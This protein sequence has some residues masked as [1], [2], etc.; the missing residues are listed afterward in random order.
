MN[1]IHIILA[2][3]LAA[4]AL[5]GWAYLGQRDKAVTHEVREQQAT[6]AAVECSNGTESLQT[7]AQER[8]EAAAPKIAAAKKQAEQHNREADRILTTPP[9]V[10][11]DSCASAQKEL[12]DWWEKRK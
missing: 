8:K 5:L 4:N 11:G 7:K 1:P 2:I 9:A 6:G 12:D 3:S 10:P